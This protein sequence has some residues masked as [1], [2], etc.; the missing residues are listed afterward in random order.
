MD[1]NDGSVD[2]VVERRGGV[3]LH[4][5]KE[6]LRPLDRAELGRFGILEELLITDT[7]PLMLKKKLSD[8]SGFF[9]MEAHSEMPIETTAIALASLLFRNYDVLVVDSFQLLN[10]A[11]GEKL[12]QAIKRT[13]EKLQMLAET[14]NLKFNFF[15]C[16]EFFETRR[17][18]E[19]FRETEA[20]IM[21][22]EGLLEL[23]RETVPEGRNRNDLSFTI[24][25]VATTLYMSV[26]KGA[27]VKVGQPRESLYDAVTR[28]LYNGIDFAYLP[29]FFALG[30][31]TAEEVTPYAP[32]S[33]TKNGG[34]RLL[35]DEI[36]G[37]IPATLMTAADKLKS[38]PKEAQGGLYRLALAASDTISPGG[39]R[40]HLSFEQGRGFMPYDNKDL[41]KAVFGQVVMPY[42][43][44]RTTREMVRFLHNI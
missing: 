31:K 33:G 39:G 13:E 6:P 26:F 43:E 29:R 14:F 16:S 30:T 25:E 42:E 5:C 44:N 7:Y 20:A 21:R 32:R 23:A 18:K 41:I 27:D 34:R 37:R 8:K 1:T 3:V 40:T 10:G 2:Y 12:N 36:D 17:Y 28:R 35:F 11:E 15:L 9:G 4:G 38:G 22:T 19:L 24:N